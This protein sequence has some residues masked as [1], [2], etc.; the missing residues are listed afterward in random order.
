MRELHLCF[1]LE[2][3]TY[4][5]V[6]FGNEA[7]ICRE[8]DYR[9]T[10]TEAEMGCQRTCVS[11]LVSPGSYS[12]DGSLNAPNALPHHP[13][14]HGHLLLSRVPLLFAVIVLA[15]QARGGGGSG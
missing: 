2:A 5:H 15:S 6:C 10:R 3:E 4:S 11:S 8:R 14:P 12:R 9:M 1:I 7:L 13:R